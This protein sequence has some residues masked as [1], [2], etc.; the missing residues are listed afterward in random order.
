[1]EQVLTNETLALQT[2]ITLFGWLASFIPVCRWPSSCGS[3]LFARS[4][5]APKACPQ[6]IQIQVL[7]PIWIRF[8]T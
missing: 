4:P 6:T 2:H 5:L 3:S 1:M 7:N 8:T